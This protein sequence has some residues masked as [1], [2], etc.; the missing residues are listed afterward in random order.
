[1]EIPGSIHTKLLTLILLLTMSS[2]AFSESP[3]N[4]NIYS[5]F[6]TH[7]MAKWENVIRT[8]ESTNDTNTVDKK[9]ELINYYYGYIGWLIGQK[10]FS[11][12]E[13]YIPRGEKLIRQVLSTCPKNATA[14]SFKGS[15]LGF[16]IGIDKYKAVFLSA[17]S[18]NCINKAL[19]LD[20]QNLQALIDKGNLLYYA[21]RI[22]GG[23]KREALNYFLKGEK[24]MESNKEVNEN[25][26]YLNLLTIIASVYEMTDNLDKAKLVYEK[27]MNNE[28]DIKWVRDGLYPNLLAR[29]KA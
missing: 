27:I 10:Q 17:D 9:L 14:Y 24:L 8:I 1:M 11:K 13:K 3:Y 25:W 29:I 7:D 18:K 20:P 5:A 22:F 21:P 4:K 19:Q 15:F 6:I 28:P 23:N 12:A 26:V 16:K 2:A